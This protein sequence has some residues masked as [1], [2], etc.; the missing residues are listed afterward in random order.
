MFHSVSLPSQAPLA[1]GSCA[2]PSVLYYIVLDTLISN[3]SLPDYI[4]VDQS[5]P[6]CIRLCNIGS[7]SSS[8]ANAI[9]VIVCSLSIG[10]D[11][12]WSITVHGRVITKSNCS[13]ISSFSV[14]LT[15]HRYMITEIYVLHIYLG[16]S[17]DQFLSVLDRRKGKIMNG[18]VQSAFVDDFFPTTVET[19]SSSFKM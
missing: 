12:T 8:S 9:P 6:S 2:L 10:V 4:W 18:R 14:K 5:S 13:T 3:L 11:F 17:D 19:H 16:N 15:V 7:S 1:R